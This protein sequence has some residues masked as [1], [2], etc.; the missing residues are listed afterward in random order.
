[1]T[2]SNLLQGNTLTPPN[3]LPCNTTP[4]T[5]AAPPALAVQLWAR[6]KNQKSSKDSN[7]KLLCS[8]FST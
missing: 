6:L 2:P 1:M 4:L 3:Q 5:S 8:G 7:V